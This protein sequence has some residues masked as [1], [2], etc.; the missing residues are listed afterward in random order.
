[1]KTLL[2]AA[3]QP[4]AGKTTV[5]AGLA[6][7][8]IQQGQKTSLLRLRSDGDD[9]GAQADAQFFAAPPLSSPWGQPVTL[10]EALSAIASQRSDSTTIIVEASGGMP[11]L[12]TAKAL[13]ARLILVARY[14]P[15]L[16]QEMAG[17]AQ[18]TAEGLAG[19]V[20]TAVPRSRLTDNVPAAAEGGLPL[21]AMLPEDRLLASLTIKEMARAL[22]A[23]VIGGSAD[24]DQPMEHLVIGS[25][26]AD[27]GYF[28]LARF[29]R[30]AVI[31]RYDKPD[32]LLAALAAEA[33]SLIIT[34]GCL[35]LEYII[36]RAEGEGVPLL[37][38]ETNTVATMQA[39]A[40]LYSATRCASLEKLERV[41]ELID[42][43]SDTALLE[44][45]I[46]QS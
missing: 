6:Y 2:V 40:E 46:R 8:L 38:V 14:S 44:A 12:E 11:L 16:W 41:A 26:A 25:I 22:N 34:G 18:H 19:V 35:P 4:L 30:K 33:A 7:K 15:D 13:E 9:Q 3:S 32:L 43:H 28:Y 20:V 36:D 5:A 45:I 17:L 21:L 24:L 1:M 29:G 31:A 27:P 42:Q 39:L 37:L 10:T 23:R